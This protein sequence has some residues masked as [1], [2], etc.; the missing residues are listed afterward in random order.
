MQQGKGQ[1]VW[2][3]ILVEGPG[4][5]HVRKFIELYVHT[6][7][8]LELCLARITSCVCFS[9]GRCFYQTIFSYIV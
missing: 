6:Y 1:V 4:I 7:L 8:T 2:K 3:V 5:D 9:L